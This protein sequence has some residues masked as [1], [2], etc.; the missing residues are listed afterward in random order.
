MVQWQSDLHVS[1][2]AQWVSLMLHGVVILLLL[3]APWPPNY[4]V[5]WMVLLTLVVLE[6]VRSQ[7]RIRRRE[8]AIALLTERR[9]R[10][11][12]KEWRI[13]RRPWQIGSAMLLM[14]RDNNGQRERLWLLRDSMDEASWRQL[15]QCLLRK[16]SV[17][18]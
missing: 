12:Q 6:S 13:T 9:L 14:L 5:V 3:L 2:Q 11:R 18:E 16:E 7:R 1:W 15:R 8:G 4:T 10:W 17:D